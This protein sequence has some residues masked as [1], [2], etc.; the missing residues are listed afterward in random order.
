MNLYD[1]EKEEGHEDENKDS[2]WICKVCGEWYEEKI[3]RC[4]ACHGQLEL[5]NLIE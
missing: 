1:L 5:K 2:L 3:K 4:L